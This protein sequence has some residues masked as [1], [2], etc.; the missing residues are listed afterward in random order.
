M[1]LPNLSA[2]VNNKIS[3]VELTSVT[4]L[5]REIY[6]SGDAV[7]K[8]VWWCVTCQSG[9]K[10]SQLAFTEVDAVLRVCGVAS[11]GARSGKCS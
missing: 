10:Q 1:K 11:G 7:P 8:E 4:S 2:S 3:V 5:R 9:V 6:L